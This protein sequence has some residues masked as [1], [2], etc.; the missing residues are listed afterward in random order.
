MLNPVGIF[1]QAAEVHQSAAFGI[2]GDT[3]LMRLAQACQHSSIGRQR[4]RVQ[5]RITA[6]Q[7]DHLTIG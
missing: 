5:F 7:P 4:G 2:N 6:A 3:A 1:Q